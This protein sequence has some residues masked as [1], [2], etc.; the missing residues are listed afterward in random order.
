MFTKEYIYLFGVLHRFQHCTGHV[1]TGNFVGRG[2]KYRQLD[3]VQ[4]CKLP[5][6]GK[7]LPT[8]PHKV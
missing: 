4:Y 8:F 2:K 7:Q 6:T 1:M 3:K 5:T